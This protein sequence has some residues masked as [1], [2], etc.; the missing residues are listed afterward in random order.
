MK[1][2]ITLLSL[3]IFCSRLS[4]ADDGFLNEKVRVGASFEAVYMAPGLKA[5]YKFND[6]FWLTASAQYAS[7]KSASKV[8]PI[9]K[10]MSVI[11]EGFLEGYSYKNLMSSLSGEFFPFSN[12]P[13]KFSLGIGHQTSTLTNIKKPS[14][15]I[16]FKNPLYVF[17]SIGYVKKFNDR[18]SLDLSVGAQIYDKYFKVKYSGSK[19]EAID[20]IDK[21]NK[22]NESAS[23]FTFTPLINIGV[24]YSF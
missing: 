9:S 16:V 24:S 2:I 4:F 12:E 3:C 19:Q 22:V 7:N 17:M 14:V 1:K 11:K 6:S 10:L 23:A 13:V 21:I 15:T 18:L 8:Y 20:A 5:S